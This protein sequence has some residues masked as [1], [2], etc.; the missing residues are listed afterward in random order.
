[1]DGYLSV[2]PLSMECE[3]FLDGY[4]NLLLLLMVCVTVLYTVPRDPHVTGHKIRRLSCLLNITMPPGP[5]GQISAPICIKGPWSYERNQPVV[6]KEKKNLLTPPPSYLSVRYM[7]LNKVLFGISLNPNSHLPDEK[8]SSR[9]LPCLPHKRGPA[10]E[11]PPRTS[12]RFYQEEF[13]FC[14]THKY[15]SYEASFLAAHVIDGS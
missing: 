15:D 4:N 1:M 11:S 6:N 8:V 2:H 13:F 9:P 14:A 3:G 12:L 7:D 10:H 5:Y